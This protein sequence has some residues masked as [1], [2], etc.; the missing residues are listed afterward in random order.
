MGL[1]NRDD[2]MEIDGAGSFHSVSLRQE[3]FRGYTADCGSDGR[4]GDGAQIADGAVP[5]E[6]DDGSLL[7]GAREPVQADFSAPYRSGHDATR[8]HAAASPAASER[9]RSLTCDRSAGHA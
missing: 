7:V 1:G 8:S 3:D 4:H 6:H 9:F 5:G 2:V